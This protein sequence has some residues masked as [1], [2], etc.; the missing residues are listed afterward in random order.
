MTPIA[1][2]VVT[3]GCLALAACTSAGGL[4]Q[5][6]SPPDAPR[7]VRYRAM[8][9][10]TVN[11]GMQLGNQGNVQPQTQVGSTNQQLFLFVF[12]N[13]NVVTVDQSNLMPFLNLNWV[14]QAMGQSQQTGDSATVSGAAQW[15]PASLSSLLGSGSPQPSP[16]GLTLIPQ[17]VAPSPTPTP[18]CY[19]APAASPTPVPT[20]VP[21]VSITNSPSPSPSAS[22]LVIHVE[23]SPSDGAAQPSPTASPASG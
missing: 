20:P 3:F 18:Y 2:L 13:H 11:N 16:S 17:A 19:V 8:V 12:G 15:D 6:A 10:S 21:T 22:P 9:L 7:P 14:N 4:S 23:A 1:R 5:S